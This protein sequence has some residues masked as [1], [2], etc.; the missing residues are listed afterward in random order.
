MTLRDKIAKAL[1]DNHRMACHP[2]QRKPRWSM[3]DEIEKD[4]WRQDADVVLEV[5]KKDRLEQM[6]REH[7]P[8]VYEVDINADQ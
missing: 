3:V 4:S 2:R 5:I 6:S 1:F 7:R 8:K